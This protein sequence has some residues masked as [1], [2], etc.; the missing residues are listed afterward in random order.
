MADKLI[1]NSIYQ[2]STTLGREL[3]IIDEARNIL[4]YN[5]SEIIS[6]NVHE[7]LSRAS[8]TDGTF[9]YADYTFLCPSVHPSS[10]FIYFA[11]GTDDLAEQ[12]VKVL[13]ISLSGIKVFHNEKYS[14]QTFFKNVVL[15]NILAGDIISRAKDLHISYEV[16]RIVYLVKTDTTSDLSVVDVLKSLFPDRNHDFV[17]SIDDRSI[18]LVKEVPANISSEAIVSIPE[19]IISTINS[20]VMIHATVGVGTP[21]PTI[22]GVAASYK[23]ATIALEVGKVFDTDKKI[24]RYDSLG[25][26]RLIYH[27]PTTL[28]EMF[29]TEIFK[30]ESID[31]LDQETIYTIQ[32][33]FENNLNVS[34]TS[35]QLYV[36]RNT[37][38]YRLDKV[39]KLTGLD[40]RIFEHAIVFKVAMMVKKYLVS[41]P[42]KI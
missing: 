16:P 12:Y 9:V 39:E 28:C 14:K 10:D 25:I 24:I 38:V 1:M 6:D 41:N 18:V 7:I 29:L 23:E 34:E 20:E 21:A 40:L 35:R 13:S 31:V 26:A 3:G 42:I 15:D 37:L 30:K 11:R 5:N 17:L 4:S 36:H 33:F 8:Y 2:L 27:L 32:K 22:N 19:S